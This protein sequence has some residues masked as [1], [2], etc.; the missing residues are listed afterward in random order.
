MTYDLVLLHAPSVYDFRK[1]VQ[2]TGP[3]ADVIPST[4]VFE[5]YPVGFTSMAG[6]LERYG[7]T[8]LIVN[9]ANRMVADPRFD[10][11]KKLKDSMP[12]PLAS[13]CTGCRMP[14][15]ASKLQNW[16]SSAIRMFL[17]YL[18]ASPPRI[19]IRN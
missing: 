1:T 8:L 12:E 11:E 10:V 16:S 7:Y 2:L 19:F 9:L 4:A 5:M 17:S 13:I 15:A 18:A 3:V 6:Y 14:T